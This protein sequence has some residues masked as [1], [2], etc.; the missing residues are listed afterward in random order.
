MPAELFG[1]NGNGLSRRQ[2][3]RPNTT[4]RKTSSAVSRITRRQRQVFTCSYFAIPAISIPDAV[5]HAIQ[6][7]LP[8]R[9][10]RG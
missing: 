8:E 9:M 1:L 10:R 4:F 6:K 7:S 3:H 2:A 5:F